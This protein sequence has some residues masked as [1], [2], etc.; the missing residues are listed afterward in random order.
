MTEEYMSD[1]I[2]YEIHIDQENNRRKQF[3]T[4]ESVYISNYKLY[5]VFSIGEY[6]LGFNS[7]YNSTTILSKI[8]N[9]NY[10]SLSSKSKE[11]VLY[12]DNITTTTKYNKI[13]TITIISDLNKSQNDKIAKMSNRI[14]DRFSTEGQNLIIYILPETNSKWTGYIED[15]YSNQKI[16]W[17][18]N[19][20]ND[21]SSNRI[22]YH[23]TVHSHQ[24][25]RNSEN[26]EWFIEGSATYISSFESVKDHNYKKLDSIIY[27][28]W[29]TDKEGDDK[30]KLRDTDT[31][32][33]DVEYHRSEHVTYLIDASLRH[34]TNGSVTIYD[35]MNWM[36]KEQYVTY[37]KFRSKIVS[38]TDEEFG[39]R[40]DYYV[41]SHNGIDVEKQ[42]KQITGS[43]EIELKVSESETRDYGLF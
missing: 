19:I 40:L 8:E 3:V 38:H 10:N 30:I 27:Q 28:E 1:S 14:S 37:S 15:R 17:V 21:F 9:N 33:Q 23:E 4:D 43:G 11:L 13:N 25:F 35:I 24:I 26:M 12:E 2:T 31:W 39:D 6:R 41:N 29:Y 7:D 20:G 36:N 16:I 32:K 34:H 42:K 5:S 22:L 18:K